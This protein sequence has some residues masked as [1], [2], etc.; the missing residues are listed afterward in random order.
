MLFN[1]LTDDEFVKVA[2][3]N[4]DALNHALEG[5]PSDKVR[6]HICWGNYEG[7]HVCDIPMAKM[8]DTLMSAKA[9]Y[10]LFETSN[11]RHGHEWTVFRDRK[12]DIPDDK[13]LVP[14]WSTRRPIS[15][16]TPTSWPSGSGVSSISWARTA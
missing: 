15:S 3:Q 5:I 6:V 9:R 8:F 1:D 14:A 16:S 11:P 12:A 4:V 10:V 2:Q 13:V 7:P